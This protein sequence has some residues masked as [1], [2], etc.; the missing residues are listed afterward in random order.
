MSDTLI[1]KELRVR[2]SAALA[3]A[4]ITAGLIPV[5]ILARAP[6]GMTVDE[7]KCPALYVFNSGEAF[8]YQAIDEVERTLFLEVVLMGRG[9]VAGDQLDDM[10][11]A[12]EVAVIAAD[13]FGIARSVRPVSVEIAQAQGAVL[14]GTRVMKFEVIFGV[15][16][17]DPSL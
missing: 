6:V 10:Q 3:G 16:P 15:T 7:K 12:V 17:G 9:D 4:G 14:F 5:N 13:G 2:F 8:Q 1:A 11:L